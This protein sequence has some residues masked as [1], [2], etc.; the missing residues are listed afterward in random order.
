MLDLECG[1]GTGVWGLDMASMS[2]MS[3]WKIAQDMFDR[4]LLP[5]DT[6]ILEFAKS[7][8]FRL[9]GVET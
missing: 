4:F 9:I 1:A 8:W 3:M 5:V 2:A 7:F 6:E